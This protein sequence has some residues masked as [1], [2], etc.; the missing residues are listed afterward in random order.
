VNGHK[1]VAVIIIG[2]G[3]SGVAAPSITPPSGFS[4]VTGVATGLLIAKAD[5]YAITVR[6]FEKVA[7][8]ESGSY[9]FTHASADTTGFMYNVAAAGT[10]NV[11]TAGTGTAWSGG[12]L[13]ITANGVTTTTADAIVICLAL[14][15]DGVGATT[16]PSGTTPTFTERLDPGVVYVAD[17]PLAAAGATGNKT[18]T[19]GTSGPN[20]TWTSLL[21]WIDDSGG[22]GGGSTRGTPFGHKGTAF[23]GGRALHGIIQRAIWLPQPHSRF[24]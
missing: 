24:A 16:P 20:N 3:A 23:N 12:S 14:G 9:A 17:G 1:L 10:I 18:I 19:S 7:S 15:W 4:E 8:G 22:G 11:G 13:V 21:V 5:P 2:T 6:V